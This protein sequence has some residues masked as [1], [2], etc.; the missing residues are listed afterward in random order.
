MKKILRPKDGAN[1]LSVSLATFWR[2]AKQ[3]DFPSKILISKKAVG[4]NADE[5][6][7]YLR[8]RT[9]ARAGVAKSSIIK[10]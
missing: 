9:V 1:R 2:I 4:W 5:I 7:E 8:S 3:E 6:D 10:R